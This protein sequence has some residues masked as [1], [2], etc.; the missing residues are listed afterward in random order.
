MEIRTAAPEY[1]GQPLRELLA[2]PLPCG[3]RRRCGNCG[4]LLRG[5]ASP[6]SP[7]E[8]ELLQKYSA[9]PEGFTWRLAC[10]CELAGPVEV[11]LPEGAPITAEAQGELPGY[12]GSQPG[13]FGLAIDIGTTTVTLAAYRFPGKE[14]LAVVS[15]MN[16]QGAHG[17]DVISRIGGDHRALHACVRAQLRDMLARAGVAPG[18]VSRAVVTGNTAMLHFFA[19]L[20]PSRMGRYPFTPRSLFGEALPWD[21]LPGAETYLPPC[22]TAFVGAD[23]ACGALAAGFPHGGG[24]ILLV[25][26]GTNGE[27]LLRANGRLRCCS[28]AAGP[29]F[30]GAEISMG[31]PALPGAVDKIW[32]EGGRLRWHSI[33]GAPVRGICGTGL[34]SALRAFLALGAI[35]ETGAVDGPALRLDGC[36]VAI[37]QRDVRKLQ[38]VKAAVA[39]GIAAMLDEAGLAPG[40]IERLWLAGG[41][42]SYL[43]P[44]DAAAIGMIPQSLAARA[45]AGGNLAL[46]GAEALLFSRKLREAA[47]KLAGGTSEIPLAEHKVFQAAFIEGMGFPE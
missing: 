14:P 31:M 44:R 22:V 16:R 17:A 9:P 4:V 12:D 39:A 46:R 27:M 33:P 28:V 41:F 6:A 25:D 10:F 24:N 35:D 5:G 13:S 34:I 11:M 2:V 23:I 15:E 19:G 38:L 26:V 40:G 21:L 8:A 29:A 20:D 37:T 42:G 3:G 47:K 45:F 7:E 43:D 30:E 32:L 36:G 1:P 18:G